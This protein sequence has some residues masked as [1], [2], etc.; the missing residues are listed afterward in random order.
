MGIIFIVAPLVG[1]RIEILQ[2]VLTHML[3]HVAPLVGARIEI[4]RAA[5]FVL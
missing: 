5:S 4:D 2:Q 1:A 3:T